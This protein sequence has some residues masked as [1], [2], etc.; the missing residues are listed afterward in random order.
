M[1]FVIE[2]SAPAAAAGTSSMVPQHSQEHYANSMTG[3]FGSASI[4]HANAPGPEYSTGSGAGN[5]G[6]GSG[7][8]AAGAPAVAPIL[9]YHRCEVCEAREEARKKD[10]VEKEAVLIIKK[11]ER[12]LKD[13]ELKT[14]KRR[15]RDGEK[16]FDEDGA[17]MVEMHGVLQTMLA[18]FDRHCESR[19][20]ALNEV[21]DH[22]IELARASG[23]DV[24]LRERDRDT[25]EEDDPED[26]GREQTVIV[27]GHRQ[28]RAA[29]SDP[30]RSLPIPSDPCQSLPT[31]A[32]PFRSL[33]IPSDPCQSLPMPADPFRFLPM[34]SD[35][36]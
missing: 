22:S 21:D 9:E 14:T 34:P 24:V 28:V 31:P 36:F 4:P 5:A 26:E 25:D 1:V 33:P 20:N 16:D 12:V 8:E 29:S 27:R 35:P 15:E 32:D 11:A 6:D 23:R 18:E 3:R 7:G 10:P 17:M 19:S 13:Y 2:S 30:C